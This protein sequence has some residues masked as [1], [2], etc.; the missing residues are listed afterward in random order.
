MENAPKMTPK[1]IPMTLQE[2]KQAFITNKSCAGG[3]IVSFNAF[4]RIFEFTHRMII[5]NPRDVSIVL[6]TFSKVDGNIL[7]QLCE[8]FEQTVL[9]TLRREDVAAKCSD[10]QYV[11]MLM[12]AD[13]E[14]GGH[15]AERLIATCMQLDSSIN[16]DITY[17]I[18]DLN[19]NQEIEEELGTEYGQRF[20]DKCCIYNNQW[21]S[22]CVENRHLDV[23]SYQ[24]DG[25]TLINRMC[26]HCGYKWTVQKE[27]HQG[28]IRKVWSEGKWWNHPL[29]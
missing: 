2:L 3:Y 23:E 19:I 14:Q 4:I 8:D 12:N 16:A 9:R 18:Y 29:E 22:Y 6:F 21:I 24:E 1:N 20:R 5:R 11:V 15:V 26:L 7:E 10:S 27:E 25:A 17:Q 28:Q 13:K